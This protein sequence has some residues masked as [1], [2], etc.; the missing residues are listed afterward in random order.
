MRIVSL[1]PSATEIVYALG[2]GDSLVGVTHECDFPTGVEALPHLTANLL[3]PDLSSAEI[4]RRVSSSM[5]ADAHTIYALDTDRLRALAPDVILTQAL[6]E[7]CAV[8]TAMVEAAVCSMPR[9]ARIFSL[10][11]FTL[12]GVITSIEQAGE[13][14][15][16]PDRGRQV[17]ASLRVELDTIRMSVAETPRPKVLAAEWLDPVYCG[18]HWLPEMIA[19]A[20][21]VDPFG[22]LGEPSH[23]LTWEMI[24]DA[25]P[26]VIV[27]MPC[28]FHASHVVDRYAEIAG[29]PTFR[30]LRAVRE[31]NVYAVDA[32][33][34]YSRPGPR[35]VEGTRILARIVHPD[36][37]AASLP[38]GAVFKLVGAEHFEPWR[39]ARRTGAA[40]SL[41]PK[42]ER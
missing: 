39:P 11:P 21:G 22:S 26:D 1:L 10:D 16:V 36:L 34:Y 31:Q 40:A 42:V 17:A 15:G 28:G 8:P 25:D 6:C 41:A 24:A 7:V 5:K 23:P 20:G 35:L 30:A 12:D 14:L 27:L 29:T 19:A 37:P 38:A 32:T 18:G 13:A 9:D 3:P 4:D 33:S 2:L